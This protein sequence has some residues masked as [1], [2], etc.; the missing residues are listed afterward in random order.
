MLDQSF[1]YLS[2]HPYVQLFFTVLFL[3]INTEDLSLISPFILAFACFCGDTF[4]SLTF[5]KRLPAWVTNMS[6][7]AAIILAVVL[8]KVI[9]DQWRRFLHSDEF[10][11]ILSTI[12]NLFWNT[13]AIHLLFQSKSFSSQ[14]LILVVILVAFITICLPPFIGINKSSQHRNK[15]LLIS[16]ISFFIISGVF[17]WNTNVDHTIETVLNSILFD[18]ALVAAID[19]ED[20]KSHIGWKI[21]QFMKKHSLSSHFQLVYLPL[22]TSAISLLVLLV[23]DL[24]NY[25]RDPQRQKA[26]K[27][28]TPPPTNSRPIPKPRIEEPDSDPEPI[29]RPRFAPNQF[30]QNQRR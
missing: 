11:P 30:A 25:L 18:N 20:N 19:P 8:Y 24:I 16:K 4:V 14:N 23:G 22:I 13:Q 7:Y 5:F 6:N 2:Y 12:S 27:P 10:R 3:C 17:L 1:T 29:R 9:P 15:D 26:Y 28:P 21:G